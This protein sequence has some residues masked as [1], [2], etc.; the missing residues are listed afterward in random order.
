MKRENELSNLVC[1][2]AQ[3]HIRTRY[4]QQKKKKQKANLNGHQQLNAGIFPIMV[5]GYSC[6]YLKTTTGQKKIVLGQ[7]FFADINFC[8][9]L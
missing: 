6:V 8:L 1:M 7:T 4:C 3:T 2:V 9:G 5:K